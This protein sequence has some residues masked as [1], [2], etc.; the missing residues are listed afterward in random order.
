MFQLLIP[1]P[2]I[3]S[4]LFFLP[5]W[6]EVRLFFFSSEYSALTCLDKFEAHRDFESPCDCPEALASFPDVPYFISL[7][8][9]YFD[10]S[11][12]PFL[13]AVFFL[14]VEILRLF[15]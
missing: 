7:P 12:F 3:P 11:F 13:F 6:R 10:F 2:D 9:N 1:L 5:P 14:S 4:A 15:S 8:S